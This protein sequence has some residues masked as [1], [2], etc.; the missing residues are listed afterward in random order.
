MGAYPRIVIN[1]SGALVTDTLHKIRF[2]P[3]VDGERVAAAIFN[4]YT[5]SQCELLGRS[6]GGG[7]LTFEP[8]EVRMI[9]FPTSNL[10][11]IDPLEADRLIRDNKMDEL[12]RMNDRILLMDGIGLSEAQV[13]MLNGVWMTLRDRRLNRKKSRNMIHKT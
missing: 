2:R 1:S 4:S 13:K 7:V 12:I 8:S 10:D 11:H 5:L 3:N 6:Y 9:P